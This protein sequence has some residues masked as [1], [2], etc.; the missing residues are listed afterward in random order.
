MPKDKKILISVIILVLVIA[1][2]S[3]ITYQNYIGSNK[4]VQTCEHRGGITGGCLP[5][6]KCS[7]D[8]DQII[9]C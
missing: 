3:V 6:G 9:D 8:S 5:E 2:V 7:G 1:A 4:A